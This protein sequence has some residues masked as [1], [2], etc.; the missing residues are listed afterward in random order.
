MKRLIWMLLLAPLSVKAANIMVIDGG[1]EPNYRFTLVNQNRLLKESCYSFDGEIRKF[2]VAH[3]DNQ[4]FSA[5]YEYIGASLC[6]DETSKDTSPGASVIRLWDPDINSHLLGAEGKNGQPDVGVPIIASDHQTVI[7]GTISENTP[8]SIKQWHVHI[9]SVIGINNQGELAYTNYNS[10]DQSGRPIHTIEAL[11]DLAE[12]FES[13]NGI[14]VI[15][16]SSFVGKPLNNP[17]INDRYTAPCDNH[18]DVTR[19]GL[20]NDYARHIKTL[21]DRGVT[22]VTGTDNSAVYP[23]ESGDL[24]RDNDKIPFPACLST[25]VAVGGLSNQEVAQGALGPGIDFVTNYHTVHP[26][27]NQPKAGTSYATP[28][29]ASYLANLQT[30]NP[31]LNNLEALNALRNTGSLHCG[32]RQYSNVTKQYCIVKPNIDAAKNSIVDSFWSDLVALFNNYQD[33]E[34]YGWNYG[35]SRHQNGVLSYFETVEIPQNKQLKTSSYNSK[36]S[37]GTISYSLAIGQPT[38]IFSFQ[39]FD[40]DTSDE[41]EV[42]VNDTS[43]GYVGKTDSNQLGQTQSVCIASEDLKTDGTNNEVKLKVKNSGETWGVTNLQIS[44]GTLNESCLSKDGGLNP[45]PDSQER[46]VGTSELFG[47]AYTEGASNSQVPLDFSVSTLSPENFSTT[48]VKRDLRVSFI[49]KS[50]DTSSTDN[51]TIVRL[52]GQEVYRSEEFFGSDERSFEFILSRNEL[53]DG[54]NTLTFL[55]RRT[56]SSMVW[57]IRNISV[58]YIEPITLS[59][60]QTDNQRYGYLETPTRLTGLRTNLAI[61]DIEKDYLLSV[62]GWG[63][64]LED[65]NEVFLNGNSLGNLSQG[66]V[67][68]LA[69]E[70]AIILPQSLLLEGLNQ[71]EFVQR[72]PSST[73]QGELFIQW[74]V[75]QLNLTALAPDFSNP[76]VSILTDVLDPSTPFTLSANITNIGEGYAKPSTLLFVLSQDDVISAAQDTV[77]GSVQ[78]I[79]INAG[80]SVEFTIEAQTNLVDQGLFVGACIQSIDDE[81]RTNNNCSPAVELKSAPATVIMAPIYQLLLDD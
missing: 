1:L 43:Y 13:L 65:E 25:T 16:V 64:D 10:L 28:K 63:I 70:T 60:D 61:T 6:Q 15:S 18:P 69:P 21:R 20:L 38:L 9:E 19:S 47:N 36:L 67:T 75:E 26:E 51:S 45:L 73:W 50:G 72:E 32:S 77:L 62:T 7:A 14:R 39:P 49:A 59:L 12:G 58:E 76:S 40:I 30:V 3:P 44:V 48:E 17:N 71:V 54:S 5:F 80:A 33:T 23:N 81:T 57:G 2:Q 52:N 8:A 24:I 34:K 55:P 79:G 29:I 37:N 4:R 22:F 53:S 68:S 35:S 56:G 41:V 78:T 74:G 31:S 42:L 27:T 66:F 46:L 11:R